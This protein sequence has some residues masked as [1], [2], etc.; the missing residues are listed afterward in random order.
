MTGQTQFE[1][2]LVCEGQTCYKKACGW[3]SCRVTCGKLVQDP[4]NVKMTVCIT[5]IVKY[6]GKKKGNGHGGEDEK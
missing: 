6:Y 4:K 5:C 1:F 2:C 3:P